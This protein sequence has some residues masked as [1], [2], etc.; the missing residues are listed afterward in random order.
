[1]SSKINNNVAIMRET[2]K[3]I[4]QLLANQDVRVVQ[5][6]VKAFVQYDRHTNKPVL[7]NLPYLPD[8]ATD[9]LIMA[10]Q[11]YL[12]HEVAHILFTDATEGKRAEALGVKMLENIIEDARIEKEMAAKFRGS[13]YN[14]SNVS[15]YYLKKRLEPKLQEIINSGDQKAIMG[16]LL[17]A[18]IR[19]WSGQHV[20]EDFMADKWGHISKLVEKCSHL[21]KDIAAVKST[22]DAVDVAVKIKQAMEETGGE[23]E[24][25]EDEGSSAEKPKQK[26]EKS[27]SRKK[28]GKNDEPGEKSEEEKPK[29]DKGKSKDDD[30][31]GEEAAE[32]GE[33]E[34]GEDDA[35]DEGEPESG[36]DDEEGEPGSDEGESESGEDEGDE[37]GMSAGASGGAGEAEGESDEKSSNESTSVDGASGGATFTPDS[38]D[39]GIAPPVEDD[40]IPLSSLDIEDM[41]ES[42][43]DE[44]CKEATEFATDANYVIFTNEFDVIETLDK[45]WESLGNAEIK[46]LEAVEEMT[47]TLQKDLERAVTAKAR[48][49]YQNGLRKGRLHG[50]SLA[51]LNFGDTRVFRKKIENHSKEVAVSIVVDLSGSMGGAKVIVATQAALAVSLVLERLSIKHEVIGFTTGS[52]SGMYRSAE[53]VALREKAPAG[54]NYSRSEPLYMPVLKGFNERL[55]P[56]V[57]ARFACAFNGEVRLRNNI[58]GECVE[59]AARRLMAQRET[60]KMMMVFSDGKPACYGNSRQLHWHLKKVVENLEKAKVNVV[61]IGIQTDAVEQ[62]YR[63]RV[64][65]NE[66]EDLPKT[67]IGQLKAALMAN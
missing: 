5:S 34:S 11:G 15:E 37:S 48:A 27:E 6:G 19:A 9:E 16:M 26:G 32:E 60:G 20:Y 58:D 31:S 33:G 45:R 8:N 39:E 65:L 22:K 55:T 46:R 54:V 66:I 14:L 7:V 42:I 40:G 12:D 63:K 25:P 23:G 52:E 36:E 67:V 21:A 64:V 62:F 28:P 29:E 53:W 4:T 2:I 24:T 38:E 50:S 18:A 30:A 41:A 13:A 3:K 61:G 59:I 51:R 57:K 49:T 10:V 44:I 56:D 17:P 47:N 43:A 35:E 1:M